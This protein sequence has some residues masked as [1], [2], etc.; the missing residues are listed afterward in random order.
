VSAPDDLDPVLWQQAVEAG[1]NAAVDSWPTD[2]SHV[3]D[4]HP[5]DRELRQRVQWESNS[6]VSRAVLEQRQFRVVAAVLN[7]AFGVL[8]QATRRAI[9]DE[10]RD[11]LGQPT[12]GAYWL[13]WRDGIMRG[14][15]VALG[16]VVAR[17]ETP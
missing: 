12:N 16:P 5:A 13:G 2:S 17:R 14:Q 11:N 6:A 9:G 8:Q 10:I 4:W 15:A 7:A 1:Q 3:S